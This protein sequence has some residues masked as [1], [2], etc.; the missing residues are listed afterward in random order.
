MGAR[1]ADELWKLIQLLF[2]S[3]PQNGKSNENN[4]PAHSSSNNYTSTRSLNIHVMQ[5]KSGGRPS[6]WKIRNSII[7]LGFDTCEFA[8]YRWM[9]VDLIA[10]CRPAN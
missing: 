8:T 7:A 10:D 1:S 4:E 3:S 5:K 2:Y 6:F 9:G